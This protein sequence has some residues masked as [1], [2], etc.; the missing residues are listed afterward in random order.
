MW[1]LQLTPGVTARSPRSCWCMN[2]IAGDHRKIDGDQRLTRLS[3]CRIVDNVKS[4]NNIGFLY[5][6]NSTFI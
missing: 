2:A 4:T 3:N 1:K 5:F 6:Y